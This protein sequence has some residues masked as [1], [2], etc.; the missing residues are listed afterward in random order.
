MPKYKVLVSEI[1]VY[2]VE[3]TAANRE[4]AE[5]AAYDNYTEGVK[6]EGRDAQVDDVEIVA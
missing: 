3:V 1:T 2:A 4:A 5:V 6:V